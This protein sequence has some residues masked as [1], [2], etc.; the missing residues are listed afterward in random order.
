M[1]TDS[2]VASQEFIN[3]RGDSHNPLS[4]KERARQGKLC[5]SA[6]PG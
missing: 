4:Q 6:P 3:E 5:N 2:K 1:I